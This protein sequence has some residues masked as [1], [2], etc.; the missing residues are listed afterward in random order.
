LSI[1]CF[2]SLYEPETI[3]NDILNLPNAINCHIDIAFNLLKLCIVITG[4]HQ[5]AL[6]INYY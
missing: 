4:N 2:A 1:L 3:I 6:T 5:H